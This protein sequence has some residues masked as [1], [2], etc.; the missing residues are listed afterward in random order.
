MGSTK[1]SYKLF[2]SY[3]RV[4]QI[5]QGQCG[6]PN[7]QRTIWGWFI[8]VYQPIKMVNLGIVHHAIFVLIVPLLERGHPERLFLGI[9]GDLHWH[10]VVSKGL[11]RALTPK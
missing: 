1:M 4:I 5:D 6:Q 3:R 11:A 7:N 9:S 8:L 10:W 2:V